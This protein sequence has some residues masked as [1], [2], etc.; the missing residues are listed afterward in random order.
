MTRVARE[1]T[2]SKLL[3]KK[4]NKYESKYGYDREYSSYDYPRS[5]QQPG[6]Y[7]TYYP[8]TPYYS[9][10]HGAGGYYQQQ[11]PSRSGS[12]YWF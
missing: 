6:Y 2:L 8:G 10:N 7:R 11:H 12:A 9:Y 3:A 5:Y 1:A 4:I